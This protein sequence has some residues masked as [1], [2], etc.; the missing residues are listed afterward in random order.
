MA[1]R[2]FGKKLSE[3]V[4]LVRAILSTSGPLGKVDWPL[5]QKLWL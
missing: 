5:N 4:T 1:A 3:L 2:G